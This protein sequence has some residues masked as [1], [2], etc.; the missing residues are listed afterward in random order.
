MQRLFM[1][2]IK[3]SLS[4]VLLYLAFR[5]VD[6][7]DLIHRFGQVNKLWILF[8]L[9]AVMV[10]TVLAALRWQQIVSLCGRDLQFSTLLSFT[11][12]GAFFNQTLPSSV[13]GDAARIWLVGKKEGWR[14][15]GY[16]VLLDRLVG[17]AALAIVVVLCLPFTV[18]IIRDPIGRI[19][20]L[21]I[22]LGA[23]LAFLVFLA[24]GVTHL[25]ILQRWSLTKHLHAVASIGF[26]IFRSPNLFSPVLFTSFL[27]HFLAATIGWGA[28]NAIGAD[29]SLKLA[30]LLILP[31]SLLTVV[32][33]SIAGWGVREGAM[34]AAFSY[35]GLPQTN[36]L[37]V[38]IV[39]GLLYLVLGA[40]GG[41]VWL[42]L[43]VKQKPS[44]A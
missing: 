19:S 39:Y 26:S 22:G 3:G 11:L 38:S 24:L 40:I 2:L 10:Q 12:V 1:F 9:G 21:V 44:I 17:V 15:A 13:G 33:V 31:V 25:R 16:S 34:V 6:I 23:L 37:A 4:G 20:V 43:G 41:L 42:S 27:I 29:L 30:I 14:L 36:G 8:S 28:A 7:E 32:P 35:A 5:A 18:Q